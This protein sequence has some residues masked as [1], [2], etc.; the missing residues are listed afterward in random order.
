MKKLT[1]SARPASKKTLHRSKTAHFPGADIIVPGNGSS[2]G[3]T[4]VLDYSYYGSDPTSNT[5]GIN[6]CKNFK[7]LDM[8]GTLYLLDRGGTP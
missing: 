1:W 4:A 5:S 8:G 3:E 7:I 6:V 2:S